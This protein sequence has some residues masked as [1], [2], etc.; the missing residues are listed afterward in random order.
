MK[1]WPPFKGAKKEAEPEVA[2]EVVPAERPEALSL[3]LIGQQ[4]KDVARQVEA[5]VSGLSDYATHN[6][7][8][9]SKEK[10]ALFKAGSEVEQIAREAITATNPY[11]RERYEGRLKAVLQK[12]NGPLTEA[13][14]A[15]IGD[16]DTRLTGIKDATAAEVNKG[17]KE[18]VGNLGLYES[19]RD[20]ER[21]AKAQEFA[22]KF[23]IA[24]VREEMLVAE[25]EYAK[26][27][28]EQYRSNLSLKAFGKELNIGRKVPKEIQERYDAS[29]LA[30]RNALSAAAEKGDPQ[31]KILAK[32]IGVRDTAVRAGEITNAARE[33]AMGEK[34]KTLLGKGIKYAKKG[35]LGLLRA[36][37]KPFE[38]LGKGLAATQGF[39]SDDEEFDREKAAKQYARAAQIV[40]SAILGTLATAG[41]GGLAGAPL[42]FR[43]ARGTIGVIGGSATGA[44][45]G[46]FYKRFFG[47]KNKKELVAA[48]RDLNAIGFTDIEA[49]NAEQAKYA[50]GNRKANEDTQKG[51]EI[52]SA[53]LVGGTSS[54]GAGAAMH[55]LGFGNLPAVHDAGGI[56]NTAHDKLA[57]P[58]I[59][60][61]T[62]H[63]HHTPPIE[64]P[65]IKIPHTAVAS[66]ATPPHASA[67]LEHHTPAAPSEHHATRPH[68]PAEHVA[69]RQSP[70][71]VHH[72]AP[73]APA[74]QHISRPAH[75]AHGERHEARE[76][77][78]HAHVTHAKAPETAPQV[79]PDTSTP[80]SR[81][82]I[83]REIEARRP[84]TA[85]EA[86]ITEPESTPASTAPIPHPEQIHIRPL[87]A[88]EAGVSEQE[89]AGHPT[90][91]EAPHSAP[92]VEA[93][94]ASTSAPAAETIPEQPVTP[95]APEV[96]ETATTVHAP[97][98]PSGVVPTEIH[99][100]P[101]GSPEI[102]HTDVAPLTP[103]TAMPHEAL[104]AAP[105]LEQTPDAHVPADTVPHPT[106]LDHSG[107][108]AETQPV[109]SPDTAP[110]RF[111]QPVN[112][113]LA[114]PE[115]SAPAH[116][117][118]STQPID[119]SSPESLNPNGFDL[120]K[121]A[122]GLDK[123]GNVFAHIVDTGDSIKNTELSYDTAL[124][125]SFK[126]PLVPVYYVQ[127]I[128]SPLGQ[129][130]RTVYALRFDPAVSPHPLP[131][132][133]DEA[134]P[135]KMPEVPKDA[136]YRNIR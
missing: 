43:I 20:K 42:V 133:P 79:E 15:S 25:G 17:L 98:A 13:L 32:F 126:N 135:Y 116:P 67:P 40:G 58:P 92:A 78:R 56:M 41:V 136:D 84:M 62:P 8:Y 72:E 83:A 131:F 74:E 119:G 90:I 47:S 2:E 29:R 9:T 111:E 99:S 16:N 65:E 112:G 3:D 71:P 76:T 86:G 53:L 81:A 103:E 52:L 80:E 24:G 104:H 96:P 34:E 5:Y 14:V 49:L 75:Q 117:E 110:G 37:N 120:S 6:N 61:H 87:T 130:T 30:W 55:Q 18:A 68:A 35:A 94:A 124:A 114:Q 22:E 73:V 88:E 38:L 100:Q 77:P 89:F 106:D 4:P 26:A 97:E 11:E 27:I 69:T 1:H 33:R 118:A 127:E 122:V 123:Q 66:G 102:T 36:Y 85:E 23:E 93:P 132:I 109:A 31:D 19:P 64:K 10:Q 21:E 45:S 95:S 82:A 101:V 12:I 91:T 107:T 59:E 7:I 28:E 48:L 57:T 128:R 108:S 50:K 125:H 70:P 115:T 105:A 60:H 129:I 39:F 46:Q 121:S 54:I 134:D 113:S 51:I 44:K 63:I